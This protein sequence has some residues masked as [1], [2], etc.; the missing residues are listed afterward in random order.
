MPVS[1][2]VDAVDDH[3][4]MRMGAIAVCH[5]QHLVLLELELVEQLPGHLAHHGLRGTVG[6]VERNDE[7]VYGLL[8]AVVLRGR[9][10]HGRRGAFRV[11]KRK[12]SAAWSSRLASAPCLSDRE[13]DTER[14][15][16]SAGRC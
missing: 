3:V 2:Q 9:R 13:V 1:S 16:R 14:G 15:R 10:P 12:I 8:D 11:I 6:R 5:D 7:M 4:H